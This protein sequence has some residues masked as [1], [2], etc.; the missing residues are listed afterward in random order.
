[1]SDNPSPVPAGNDDAGTTRA[2]G[3]AQ[4][5]RLVLLVAAVVFALV[6]LL[7]LAAVLLS[8]WVGAEP[9]PGFVSAAYF[10]LPFGFLLM[11]LTLVLSL[12]SRVRG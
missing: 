8:A 1:M 4:R 3:R 11:I 9:W 2:R 12:F 7:S 5:A 10:C 6:G